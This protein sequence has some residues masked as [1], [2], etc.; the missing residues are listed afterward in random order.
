MYFLSL[1][2]ADFFLVASLPCL[3]HYYTR[4][5]IWTFS[6]RFCQVNLFMLSMNRTANI[7]F[8]TAI[9][10]DHYFKVVHPHHQLS[11]LSIPA[12]QKYCLL[13]RIIL[14]VKVMIILRQTYHWWTT[15]ML[16]FI[17]FFISLGIIFFC[18]F[19][20]LFKLKQKKMARGKSIQ[21]T[22]RLLIIIVLVYG[23]CFLPVI[24]F[25]LVGFI[26]WKVSPQSL[27]YKAVTQLFHASFA[28]TYLNSALD[29]VL[30]C[31]SS[32]MLQNR[33]KNVQNIGMF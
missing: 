4:N 3:M 20:V 30:Y 33:F 14:H 12:L 2:V 17:E 23:V 15:G 27:S 21:R 5:E 29:P 32:P 28:F 31:F 16:I 10:V 25:A 11:K 18:I 8:F 9:A 26:V 22:M 13:Y 6:K 19:H 7:V 24:L 1:V